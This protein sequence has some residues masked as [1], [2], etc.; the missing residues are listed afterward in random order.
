MMA[1]PSPILTLAFALLI[2]LTALGPGCTTVWEEHYRPI[3]AAEP[4]PGGQK[5]AMREI[6]WERMEKAIADARQ[7]RVD[8]DR[9]FSEWS[10]EERL[11]ARTALLRDLQFSR[12]PEEVRVIGVSAFRTTDVVKPWDG[13]LIGF[14]REVGA[15]HVIWSDRYLGKAQAIVDRTVYIDQFRA[16]GA[17]E[18][19][20]NRRNNFGGGTTTATVPV[21]VDRDERGYTSF[22]LRVNGGRPAPSQ[23]DQQDD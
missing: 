11:E 4:I 3:S 20:G 8:D 22:F 5:I 17:F 6:P 9:H 1:R 10:D 21:V 16:T 2:P 18:R 7:R 19:D 13:S 15:T 23:N 14:A 12:N